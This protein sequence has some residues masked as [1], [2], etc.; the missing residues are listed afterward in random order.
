MITRDLLAP[1][2]HSNAYSHPVHTSFAPGSDDP[3]LDP[4]LSQIR[5]QS[6]LDS[7]ASLFVLTPVTPA[8]LHDF[9]RSL[10]DVL[11]EPALEYY[12][13][14]SKRVRRKRAK[15][16]PASSASGG[17][18]PAG[19]TAGRGLG[20][21]G[22]IVRYEYKAGCFAEIRGEMEVVSGLSRRS[23][24]FSLERSAPSGEADPSGPVPPD[25]ISPGSKVS[26]RAGA[27]SS[28]NWT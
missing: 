26:A 28:E 18:L 19:G 22:W 15:L 23:L 5:R 7:R 16:G 2:K 3:S 12:Q 11:Y 20:R 8:E 17:G 1:D 10:Q 21:E 24:F 27:R 9:V 25:L 6:S 14:H 4:R 13:Q